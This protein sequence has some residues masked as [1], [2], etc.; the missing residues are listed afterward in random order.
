M[1]FWQKK[2]RNDAKDFGAKQ[3]PRSGGFWSWKG[4]S[5]S[6]KYLIESKSSK[7]NRFSVTTKMWK[8]VNREAL[9]SNRIPIISAIFGDEN[10]EIVVLDKYDF[11]ELM[12]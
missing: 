10:I 9:L 4:D 5:L 11:I 12:K 8:K 7:H 2:E 1:K 3:S 6:N